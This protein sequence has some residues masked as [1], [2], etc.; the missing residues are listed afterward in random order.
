M[1]LNFDPVGAVFMDWNSWLPFKRL[2]LRSLEEMVDGHVL[3][4]TVSGQAPYYSD[5]MTAFGDREF[6]CPIRYVYNYLPQQ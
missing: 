6:F 1:F 2:R 4:P 3:C 5:Q